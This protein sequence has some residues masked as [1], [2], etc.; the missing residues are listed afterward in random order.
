M[1]IYC[2]FLLI[3]YSKTIKICIILDRRNWKIYYLFEPY[4]HVY[5][6]LHHICALY[7]YSYI[8][9]L[10]PLKY[11][12]VTIYSESCVIGIIISKV[13]LVPNQVILSN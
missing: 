5:I 9:Y 8:L 3:I 12:F 4:M 2:K 7:L 11:I 6:Y 10:Y 1:G 13:Y